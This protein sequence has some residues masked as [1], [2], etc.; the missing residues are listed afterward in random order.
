MS[1]PKFSRSALHCT[2]IRTVISLNILSITPRAFPTKSSTAT[3][4]YKKM[5]IPTIKDWSQKTRYNIFVS[6][7]VLGIVILCLVRVAPFYARNFPYY[8]Y[9][10][11]GN[12]LL[13]IDSVGR[14]IIPVA[15]L[16]GPLSFY[17]IKVASILAA[18][19]GIF[20]EYFKYHSLTDLTYVP[21]FYAD[22]RPA[23]LLLVGRAYT[24]ICFI[25]SALLLCFISRRLTGS[26]LLG[27]LSAISFITLPG[28]S[29][30]AYFSIQEMPIIF[31]SLLLLFLTL[32]LTD[33]NRKNL[34]SIAFA[35]AALPLLKIYAAAFLILP[36]HV[37]FP[38][39]R[40][41]F[42]WTRIVGLAKL[43]TLT[44]LICILAY[45][46]FRGWNAFLAMVIYGD[47]E[48]SGLG[49]LHLPLSSLGGMFFSLELG[50]FPHLIMFFV[51]TLC[52]FVAPLR[53]SVRLF[54]FVVFFVF[55]FF[56]RYVYGNTRN[57]VTLALII[58]LIIPQMIKYCIDGHQKMIALILFFGLTVTSFWGAS[59]IFNTYRG[60][61]DTRLVLADQINAIQEKTTTVLI[62]RKV[63][64]HFET[65]KGRP[66]RYFDGLP[67]PMPSPF[68]LV[69]SGAFQK[70]NG[71][72]PLTT[73]CQMIINLSGSELPIHP[74]LHVSNPALVLYTC[75]G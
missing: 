20:P 12:I 26:I 59:K 23:S 41:S 42:S 48:Y 27:A 5:P 58:P 3:E 34:V 68:L 9:I 50:T 21:L 60:E 28:I 6:V 18:L 40:D 16:Y 66:L 39:R 67:P 45:I 36:L 65:I 1:S 2:G 30:Y 73:R 43:Y 64:I 75:G 22:I 8:N 13:W 35:L 37:I 55:I 71:M 38:L 57:I 70:E 72:S 32:D 29:A 7:T 25:G 74:S 14:Q 53:M 52:I 4:I 46:P 10:D 44:F 33:I 51:A 47:K 61:R 63:Q 69:T 54:C 17:L 15:L 31:F 24:T 11:E 19:L 62:E 49:E 56:S